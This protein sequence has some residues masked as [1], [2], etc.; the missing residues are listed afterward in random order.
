MRASWRWWLPSWPAG[1]I[2]K[3]AR[4]PHRGSAFCAKLVRQR[5]AARLGLD[6]AGAVPAPSCTEALVAEPWRFTEASVWDVEGLGCRQG[7]ESPE[8]VRHFPRPHSTWQRCDPLAGR[9]PSPPGSSSCSFSV[10]LPPPGL[11]APVLGGFQAPLG[12][13]SAFTSCLHKLVAQGLGPGGRGV[14]GLGQ[15]PPPHA[16]VHLPRLPLP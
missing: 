8:R 16:R 2:C 10:C 15:H 13:S 6:R 11:P 9:A 7:D 3:Q 4:G 1:V 12:S 5:P 14:G